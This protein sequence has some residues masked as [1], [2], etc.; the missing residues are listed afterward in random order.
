MGAGLDEGIAVI[1]AAVMAILGIFYTARLQRKMLR[2]QH[3]FQVIDKLNGWKELDEC[4][5]FAA[6]LIR[7]GKVPTLCDDIHAESCEKIDFL[8]NYYEVLASAVICGDV[9]EEL[10]FRM[11]RGRLTRAYLAFIPYIDENRQDMLS[12]KL[13]ENL[14]FLTYRWLSAKGDAFETLVDQ[15]RL[16]PTVT[17]YDFRRDEIR[18]FLLKQRA[19]LLPTFG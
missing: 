4:A 1:L 3:T 18:Q 12:L 15:M 10:V 5:D 17:G 14:E 11:E 16:R 8:L 9:D 7:A 6:K 2:K 19:A 13:W